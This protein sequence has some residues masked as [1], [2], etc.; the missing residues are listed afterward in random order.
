MPL[1]PVLSWRPATL[2]RPLTPLVGRD[3]EQQEAVA[4]L[5]ESS[6]RLLTL[7]GPGGVG[8]TRL[9]LHLA[10]ELADD[11]VDGVVFVSLSPLRDPDLVLPT[12]ARAF[13][14]YETQM[15][16]ADCEERL[17]AYLQPRQFLLVL[18]NF[19]QIVSAA[20]R[21]STILSLCPDITALV[22]SQVPL[23]IEGEQQF[24]VLP[25][26][27]PMASAST[28][29]AVQDT[30][31]VALFMQ[32]ARAVAPRLTLTAANATTIATICRQLDGL[33]LALE[34][35]AA[36]M[37][38]LSPEALL[39]RLSNRLQVLTGGRRDMPDR[40]RTMRQAIAWSYDLL[41]PDEQ[42]LFRQLSVFAGGIPIDAVEALLETDNALDLVSSL[43]DRSLVRLTTQND[44]SRFL[45]LETLRDFGHEELL[46]L[47]QDDEARAAH[48]A[49]YG[50]LTENAESKLT[51]TGQEV[52]LERFTTE[53]NNLRTALQWSLDSGHP[54]IALS[55]LHDMWRFWSMRGLVSEGRTWMERAIAANAG[56]RTIAFGSLL[57]GAGHLA[58]DQNDLEASRT[59]FQQ[60]VELANEIGDIRGKIRAIA[61]LGTVAHDRGEYDL[62]SRYHHEAVALSREHNEP[63]SMAMALGNLGAVSYYRADYEAAHRHWAEC[64]A[65]LA[66]LG[67]IQAEAI[68][69]SNLGALAMEREDF[70][71]AEELLTSTVE[72]QRQIGDERSLAFSFV[73]LADL[74]AQRRDVER[75]EEYFAIGINHFRKAG[76]IRNEAIAQISR[77]EMLSREGNDPHVLVLLVQSARQLLR[78]E[79]QLSFVEAIERFAF[80][81]ARHARY[82]EAT[83][84]YGLVAAERERLGAPPR[85][86]MLAE[87][88]AGTTACERALSPADFAEAWQAG[89]TL[90]FAD[91]I[92]VMD[93]I[94]QDIA[95]QASPGTASDTSALAPAGAGRP[96]IVMSSPARG[97]DPEAAPVENP[98]TEREMDVLRL[99]AEGKSSPEI[100]EE[101][102]I[103]PRTATT[104]VSRILAKLE[105]N[106]RTAAVTSAMRLGII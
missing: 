43:V 93:A 73:N 76:D 89:A 3:R 46:R 63:R 15:T 58:E 85:T 51:A 35:A 90:A 31:A 17:I 106:S 67:D 48:A 50:S 4:I 36:R 98:L 95:A 33:P 74:W 13:D 45:M 102:F 56:Q 103:S 75:A 22:T 82:T 88:E 28:P 32:R 105:V 39:A 29:D 34:L 21:I 71:L 84:L 16:E 25:L 23:D 97:S 27:V 44:E 72:M 5:R 57:S 18:D 69:T 100:A 87:V 77:A 26:E 81:A 92:A 38:I 91:A 70:E 24:P 6:P 53:L 99:L 40:L 54:D 20:T 30:G 86:R 37:N 61:G 79:D 65:I 78:I 12:I 94:A 59:F 104:H 83:R 101:L 19:E 42:A 14:I 2:P 55:L 60:A 68:V 80:L 41:T 52:W 10:H 64:R 96:M 1:A 62:A 49:Y 66:E 7:T 8:K 47:G 9:A 11:F